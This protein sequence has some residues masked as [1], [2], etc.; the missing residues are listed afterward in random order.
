VFR[1]F[2]F[3]FYCYFNFFLNLNRLIQRLKYEAEIH[4]KLRHPNIVSMLG[5]VFEPN[6]YGIILEYVTCGS[7]PSFLSHVAKTSGKFLHHHHHKHLSGRRC[8]SITPSFHPSIYSREPATRTSRTITYT[9][10]GLRQIHILVNT[11][12]KS[13]VTQVVTFNS[14]QTK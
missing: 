9:A 5:V 13:N 8:C 3:Y 14:N 7:W 2:K 11:S 10:T 6:N 4:S 12:M 1:Q